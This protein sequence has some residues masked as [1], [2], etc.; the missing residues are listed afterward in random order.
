MSC[1]GQL[2]GCAVQQLV[3]GLIYR[4]CRLWNKITTKLQ[5]SRHQIA[6]LLYTDAKDSSIETQITVHLEVIIYH[7][8]P[9]KFYF[10]TA[11]SFTL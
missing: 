9:L 11:S 3:C 8:L 10:F 7:L 6:W 1:V 5:E 2:L 4:V